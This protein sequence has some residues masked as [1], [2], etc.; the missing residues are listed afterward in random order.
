MNTHIINSMS[1][2][3]FW[4][5]ENAIVRAR[6]LQN[7]ALMAGAIEVLQQ[8]MNIKDGEIAVLQAE[9]KELLEWK[10]NTLNRLSS[11]S[12]QLRTTRL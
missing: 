10:A 2:D 7:P 1:D 4:E 9:V 3:D 5:S 6:V 12:R 11:M 8:Q